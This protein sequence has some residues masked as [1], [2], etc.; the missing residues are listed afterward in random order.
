MRRRGPLPMID[1]GRGGVLR[2][3]SEEIGESMST[4][5]HTAPANVQPAPTEIALSARQAVVLRALVVAYIDH[6]EPVASGALA[7]MIPT[8][9]SSASIRNTLAELHEAGLIDKAHASAGRVPTSLGLRVF[10]DHLVEF[11]DLGPDHQRLLERSLEGVDAA[12]TPRH[13]SHLLSEHTRQLGFVVAPRVERMRMRTIHLVQVSSERL[14]AVLVAENG[15]VIERM[16]ET[17]EPLP[18]RSLEKVAALLAEKITGRTL[19]GLQEV[20]ERERERLQGEADDLTRSVWSLGLSA[21]FA[22]AGSELDSDLVITTRIA[23]LDQ[24]EFSNPDRIRGLFA[25]LETNRQLLDLLHRIAHAD[26]GQMR[27]GLTMSLGT[28]LGEPSLRDCAL[29]AVPYGDFEQGS[30]MGTSTSAPP[31]DRGGAA[32]SEEDDSLGLG[33]LGVIGPQRMDYGKVIP[34]VRF[35]SDLVTRKFSNSS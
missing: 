4:R 30:G 33:V 13:A 14:L 26:S 11:A 5:S 15:G 31:S 21:C 3:H 19:L 8:P 32:G 2:S 34:L 23:L 1:V 25:A 9:L 29:L 35:C 22:A 10:V 12:E 20:L 18:K 16:I 17:V 28:D 7:L 6:A 24:P 27:V